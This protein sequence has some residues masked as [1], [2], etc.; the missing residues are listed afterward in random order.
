VEWFNR[1]IKGETPE[2][3]AEFHVGE[4]VPAGDWEF[5][6]TSVDLKATYPGHVTDGSF[7]EVSIMFKSRSRESKPLEVKLDADDVVVLDESGRAF[8]PK[9]IPV[10]MSGAK[11]LILGARQFT[12]AAIKEESATYVPL[13]LTFELPKG[14]QA[15]KLKVKNFPLINLRSIPN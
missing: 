6:V 2:T 12:A 4:K 15:A 5:E 3:R 8:A 9:G 13:V 7:V 10:E 11:G 1:Y 14:S